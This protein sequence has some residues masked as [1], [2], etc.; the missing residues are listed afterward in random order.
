[1]TNFLH[2]GG[3][4]SDPAA[5]WQNTA[6]LNATLHALLPGDTLL[7]P[8]RT[9]HVMG[10]IEGVGLRDVTIQ[11]DGKLIFSPDT[12]AWP[13]YADDLSLIHI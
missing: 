1:M 6:T 9:F 2:A 10:G 13:R 12:S 7:I 3:I 5:A 8:R 11:I 4:P